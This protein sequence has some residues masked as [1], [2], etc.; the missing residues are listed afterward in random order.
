MTDALSYFHIIIPI[1]IQG[2][3]EKVD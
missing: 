3:N 2:L 1:D